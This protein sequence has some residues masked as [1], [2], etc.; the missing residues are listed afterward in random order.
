MPSEEDLVTEVV[1]DGPAPQALERNN[2][3][4]TTNCLSPPCLGE[5]GPAG[6]PRR[7]CESPC[8]PSP[9]RSTIEVPGGVAVTVAVGE[10]AL[11]SCFVDLA[12]DPGL[13]R[14]GP[15]DAGLPSRRRRGYGSP[16]V[17]DR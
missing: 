9:V 10:N 15:L 12:T 6:M 8:A 2:L 4:G 5:G 1:N 3:H 14:V 7:T 16:G 17:S 11:G 13:L